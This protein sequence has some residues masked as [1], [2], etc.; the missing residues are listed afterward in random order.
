MGG[1]GRR[2][3]EALPSFSS[4]TQ[5][6][7]ANFLPASAP[8]EQALQLAGPLGAS[9]LAPVPVVA[10]S[11]QGPLTPADPAWLRRL[12]HDLGQVPTVA[13]VRDLGHSPAVPPTP[14][15]PA[16]SGVTELALPT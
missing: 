15:V 3:A 11:A 8:S 1:G 4:V 7:N 14:A 12:Q 13:K 6:N 2:R 10:A 9:T 5:G 16:A